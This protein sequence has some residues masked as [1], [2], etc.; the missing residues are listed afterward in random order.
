MDYYEKHNSRDM[1]CPFIAKQAGIPDQSHRV[2]YFDDA[3]LVFYEKNVAN[4][5]DT[6]G[7]MIEKVK[8]FMQT[9]PKYASRTIKLAANMR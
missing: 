4:L 3:D 2:L 5:N 8:S 7:E 9:N 6:I 1:M